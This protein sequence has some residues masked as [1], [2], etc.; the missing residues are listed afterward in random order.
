MD[1]STAKCFF[2]CYRTNQLCQLC[3]SRYLC[4]RRRYPA[5]V[6]T[7][8]FNGDGKA[9]MVV[10]NGGSDNISVLLSN[11]NGTFAAAVPYGSEALSLLV[12]RQETSTEMESQM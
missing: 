5:A 10:A 2:V 8:D 1:Y 3:T 12:L 6:A 11:D 9:D 4:Q 7:A